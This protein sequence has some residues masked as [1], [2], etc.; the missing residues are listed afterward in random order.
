MTS[1]VVNAVSYRIKLFS[2]ASGEE[3]HMLLLDGIALRICGGD[4]ALGSVERELIKR[5][6]FFRRYRFAAG[7][8]LDEPMDDKVRVAAYGGS[9]VRIE[10]KS[11]SEVADVPRRIYR[12]AH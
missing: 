2:D 11:E 4:L 6:H 7:M 3:L 9:E 8:S 5:M 10:V 1:A 12:L